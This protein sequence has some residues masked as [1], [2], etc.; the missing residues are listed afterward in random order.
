V[1]AKQL[2]RLDPGLAFG[3]GT[4]PRMHVPEVDRR[5]RSAVQPGRVLDY[6]CGSGILAIAAKFERFLSMRRGIPA[7]TPPTPKPPCCVERGLPDRAS[8]HYDAVLSQHPGYTPGAGYAVAVPTW[9]GGY[10][11]LAGI[12]AS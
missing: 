7:A 2:I 12:C 5:T 3:T 8:G 11:V 6:G 9:R 1:Q 4:R 10:L